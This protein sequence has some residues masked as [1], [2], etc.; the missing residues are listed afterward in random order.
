[1]FTNPFS[2]WFVAVTWAHRQLGGSARTEWGAPAIAVTG[3]FVSLCTI[4][5]FRGAILA[6]ESQFHESAEFDEGYDNEEDSKG[7]NN[8]GTG[9]EIKTDGRKDSEESPQ[10]ADQHRDPDDQILAFREQDG[11]NRRNN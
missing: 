5:A 8:G 7:R 2:L 4:C 3:A 10:D 9:R 1:M 6:K 11:S